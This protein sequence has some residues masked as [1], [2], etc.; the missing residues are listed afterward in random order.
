M[1][2]TVKTLALIT[3]S[4]FLS[5]KYGA[6]LKLPVP[7]VIGPDIKKVIKDYPNQFNNLKGEVIVQNPQSTDYAC[8]FKVN[9]AEEATVTQYSAANKYNI[10]SWQA[11]ILTT[12]EFEDAKK[13]Y[14]SLYVQL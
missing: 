8:N 13:K 5:I 9:G 2:R 7:N 10:C 14:K 12:E 1:S 6:Q 3:I 11:L 4:A